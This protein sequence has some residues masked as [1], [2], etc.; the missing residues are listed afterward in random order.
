MI[1]PDPVHGQA[2]AAVAT[3][4]EGNPHVAWISNRAVR[5]ARSIDG[6]ATFLAS[7]RVDTTGR[8]PRSPDIAIDPMENPH[9]SWSDVNRVRYAR[10]MDGGV[11]FLSE[12]LASPDA[13][14]VRLGARIAVDHRCDPLLVWDS[15]DLLFFCRSWDEGFTFE[16]PVRVDP[17]AAYSERGNIALDA[18]GGVYI[19]YVGDR[20]WRSGRVRATRSRDCGM[21]FENPVRVDRSSSCNWGNAIAVKPCTRSQQTGG[22]AVLVVWT[23][24][25]NPAGWN[26]VYLSKSTDGGVTFGDPVPIVEDSSDNY[27]PSLGMDTLG[28]VMVTWRSEDLIYF[29]S[30]SDGGVTFETPEAVDSTLFSYQRSP[31]LAATKSGVPVLVWTDDRPPHSPVSQVYFTKGSRVGCSES[32]G[33]R[34]QRGIGSITSV[35][36]NPFNHSTVIAY[37][38]GYKV[39]VRLSIHDCA[40]RRVRT[41]LDEPSEAGYHSVRWTEPR[42]SE[43]RLPSGVYIVRLS[44]G[45][46]VTTTKVVLIE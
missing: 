34:E 3:D 4:S 38:V 39:H 25:R 29:S 42:S 41:L 21:T 24:M 2:S 36:P 20:W 46:Y 11:S 5:Y 7:V 17:H 12:V 45:S 14:S 22:V 19:S 35:H 33:S 43:L 8:D 6:G 10:S 30:S 40:G 9:I 44:A 18:W 32:S 28:N 16:A 1:E 27:L 31:D 15:D 26:G 13:F 37:L 23:E